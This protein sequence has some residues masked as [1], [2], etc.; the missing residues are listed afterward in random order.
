MSEVTISVFG[1]CSRLDLA[2]CKQE[3]IYDQ[4]GIRQKRLLKITL[5]K[6]VARIAK[7]RKYYKKMQPGYRTHHMFSRLPWFSWT[8]LLR[9]SSEAI[10][11]ACISFELVKADIPAAIPTNEPALRFHNRYLKTTQAY[12]L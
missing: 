12:Y 6:G 5:E 4:Y 1:R 11:Y 8:P 10:S 9:Y 3:I 2:S 7:Q